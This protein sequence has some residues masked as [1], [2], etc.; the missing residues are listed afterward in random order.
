[1]VGPLHEALPAQLAT[2]NPLIDTEHRLLL[3]CIA[4]LRRICH[5]PSGMQDCA[6]CPQIEQDN[7]ESYLVGMLGDLLAFIL[8]HFK[9]EE[10]MMRDSLLLM[11][12]RDLCEAHMED[13]AAISGKVQQIVAAL[14]PRHTARLIREL[15][16]LLS[17]WLTN[18]VALHDLLLTR[19]V[20]REDSILRGNLG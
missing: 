10:A 19:W 7:C 2:G 15:D 11:V 6:G 16:A 13:H 8:E 3:S 5:L 4:N 1:M 18:H 17:N 9:T 12:D 14:D 20:E